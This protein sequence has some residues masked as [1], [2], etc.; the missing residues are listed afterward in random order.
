MAE[1]GQSDDA[2]GGQTAASETRLDQNLTGS[3]FISYASQDAAIATALVEYLERS[4]VPCWIAPRDVDAGALY[5]D[6]IV[7]AISGARAC[8]LVLSRNSI[9]SS[10]VGKEVE[11]A[12]SKKRPIFAVRIDA[13]PLTPALEYFLSESQWVDAQHGKMEPAYAKLIVAIRKS[14]PTAPG[15]IPGVPPGAS[16]TTASTAGHKSRARI[17]LA[18]GLAVLVVVVALFVDR[19][20]LAKH[21]IPEQA[22]VPAPSGPVAAKAVD[23]PIS[24]KSIAVLP[25]ADMSEKKDQEYFSDGLSE[26][27]IDLLTKVPELQ[28]PAR[29]SSFYFKGQHVTIADIAKALSVAYVLEGSVRKA[30]STIRVRTELIRAENG[31]DVWSETYDRDLKDIF[32]VQDDIAGR[33]VA[34]LKAAMPAVK[35]GDAER[36]DNTEAYN[37]YLLA[38]NFGNQFTVAGYRHAVEAYKRA[39]TL[40]PHYAGAYAGLAEAEANLGDWVGDPGGLTRA[41]AAAEQAIALAPQAANGYVIRGFLRTHYLWDWDGASKDFDQALSVDPNG[42]VEAYASDLAL[43]QG[44]LT[45]AITLQSR[46]TKRNPLVPS[47]WDSLGWLL[48]DAGRTVEARAALA[49]ALEINPDFAIAHSNLTQVDLLDGRLDQALAETGEIHDRA[50][51]LLATALVQYS[52]HHPQESHQAL[53]ELIKTEALEMSYQI[54][55][56]HAW[57]GE[58]DQAFA[59]LDRAYTQRDGGLIYLKVDWLFTSLRSD[60]RYK[61]FLRKMNLP[62]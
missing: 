55:E 11:R 37:Q 53:D 47:V 56:I 49:R 3:V 51:Q 59:W 2:N 12:S 20:W 54:G 57:R 60:P 29:A 50:W 22:A 26:D 14:V 46:A 7:R 9:D 40:D 13:A 61:A 8:V 62:E 36:T 6:A 32:K 38:R 45:D 43:A 34:S 18:A 5:A 39:V 25:F 4:G 19:F 48:L 21:S 30:G 52:L 1:R 24:E 15:I 28:V 10:H 33:V 42:N 31:Y 44:R 41:A 17:V 27:L 23:T 16:D 58:K 35:T